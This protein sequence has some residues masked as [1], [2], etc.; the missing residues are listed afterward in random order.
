MYAFRYVWVTFEILPKTPMEELII[1]DK[2]AIREGKVK[3]KK[4]L[5]ERYK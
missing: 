3:N 4:Q 5:D 1:C 2:C